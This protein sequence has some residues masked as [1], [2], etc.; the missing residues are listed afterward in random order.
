MP[1]INQHKPLRE[2]SQIVYFKFYLNNFTSTPRGHCSTH[3]N[4]LENAQDRCW[5]SETTPDGP[6]WQE[7][8]WNWVSFILIFAQATWDLVLNCRM[9]SYKAI[10]KRLGLLSTRQQLHT[11]DTIHDAMVCLRKRFPKAGAHDMKS[12]LFHQMGMSVPRCDLKFMYVNN[13]Q[14]KFN[15]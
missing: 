14:L 10:R 4:L 12:L 11:L 5:D 8:L 13:H 15:S 2:L 7:F 1:Q 3:T 6:Y 9:T